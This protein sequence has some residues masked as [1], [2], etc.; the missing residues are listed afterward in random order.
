MC[1]VNYK[2]WEGI[3][4]NVGLKPLRS[5]PSQLL[6][7]PIFEPDTLIKSIWNVVSQI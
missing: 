7:T 6:A 2:P 3:S 5:R 1:L 4:F